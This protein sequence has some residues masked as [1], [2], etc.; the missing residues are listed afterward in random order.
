MTARRTSRRPKRTSRK[1]TRR[2][3]RGLR[4]NVIPPPP[5]HHIG[6]STQNIPVFDSWVKKTFTVGTPVR[7]L[8]PVES[9]GGA[10]KAGVIG[11]EMKNRVFPPGTVARVRKLYPIDRSVGIEMDIVGSPL[12]V[13]A[14]PERWWADVDFE[15]AHTTLQPLEDNWGPQTVPMKRP[16]KGRYTAPNKRTSR[17]VQP[18]ATCPSC[19][20]P[21]YFEGMWNRDCA[22][23]ECRYFTGGTVG[24]ASA[25]PSRPRPTGGRQILITFDTTTPESLAEGDYEESGERSTIDIEAE[26][27]DEDET[28]AEYAANVIKKELGHVDDNGDGTYYQSEWHV[29]DYGTGEEERL[30]AHLHPPGAWAGDLDEIH[31]LL[32]QW[33]LL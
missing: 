30:A 3:S 27:L 19:G 26:D 21:H 5:V 16:M 29:T 13:T 25:E 9:F 14:E 2:T 20:S 28:W 24:G 4:A 12:L 10:T 22:T 32:K 23:P 11:G 33:R 7:L 31:E 17:R 15:V 8:K 18:N 6:G 1:L